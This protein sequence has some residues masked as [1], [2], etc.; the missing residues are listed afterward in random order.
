MRRTRLPEILGTTFHAEDVLDS[1]TSGDG[2]APREPER[3]DAN[4]RADEMAGD[5]VP[6]ENAGGQTPDASSESA[7]SESVSPPDPSSTRDDP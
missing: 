1:D 7:S 4:A 6:G 2:A 3:A 5:G